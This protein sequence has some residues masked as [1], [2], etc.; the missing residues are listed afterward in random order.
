MDL[1]NKNIIRLIV[2][3]I[4]TISLVFISIP[5]WNNINNNTSYASMADYYNTGSYEK[6]SIYKI[7]DMDTKT[8]IPT[9]DNEALKKQGTIIA[10]RNGSNYNISYNLYLKISKNSTI[11][12][13]NLKISVNDKIYNLSKLY[14]KD[15]DK[16][17]F[18]ILD[19]NT[20]KKNMG[21]KYDIKLWLNETTGN[22]EQGKLLI[23]DFMYEE[24]IIK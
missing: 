15:N 6:L 3:I 2:E 16:Y 1:V 7:Q 20:V 23:Y 24:D 13:N 17:Y 11:N 18:Y 8:M 12:K 22:N 21:N 19:N 4:I 14:K 5:V 10:I 9:S